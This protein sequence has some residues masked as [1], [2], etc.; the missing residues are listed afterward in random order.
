MTKIDSTILSQP[1]YDGAPA[2]K[3]K[4]QKAKDLH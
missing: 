4:L 1:I 2:F 3:A